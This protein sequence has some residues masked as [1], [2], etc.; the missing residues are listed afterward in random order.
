MN[1][2]ESKELL[3]EKNFPFITSL[4]RKGGTPVA[5]A[6]VNALLRLA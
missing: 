1:A 6:L 5:V 2:A 3:A 4:G